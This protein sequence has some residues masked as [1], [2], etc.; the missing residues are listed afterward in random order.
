MDYNYT[1]NTEYSL[2]DPF[3]DELARFQSLVYDAFEGSDGSRRFSNDVANG[4][5][6][7]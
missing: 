6:F 2:A 4:D 3:K 1:G 5:I 7:H